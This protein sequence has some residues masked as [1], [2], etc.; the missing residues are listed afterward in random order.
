[1]DESENHRWMERFISVRTSE[2]VLDNHFPF[3]EAWN[4]NRLPSKK[5]VVA[6]PDVDP[7]ASGGRLAEAKMN[8]RKLVSTNRGKYSSSSQPPLLEKQRRFVKASSL[9]PVVSDGYYVHTQDEVSP[10]LSN[11][12]AS[13]NRTGALV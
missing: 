10:T 8:N 3:P 13:S 5:V 4:M 6:Y 9:A 7:R 11:S 1:M 2:I 12:V